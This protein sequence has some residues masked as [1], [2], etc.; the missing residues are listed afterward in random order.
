MMKPT[1]WDAVRNAVLAGTVLQLA[2]VVTGHWV[3]S[4]AAMFAVLGMAISL[5]A[6]WLATYRG[7]SRGGRAALDGAIA[8]GACALIGIV[9]SY[10]LGD[11]TA[12]VIGFG[13]VSSAVT[14][15]FGGFAG[16]AVAARGRAGALA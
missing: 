2:M 3:A 11:V 13:T 7:P 9:V 16:G 14:G 15:A 10:A 1:R 5:L 12:A 6:G 4:I 8:G